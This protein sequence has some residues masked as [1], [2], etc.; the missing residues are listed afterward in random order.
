[1]QDL[2]LT[3]T[4]LTERFSSGPKAC[5]KTAIS[6]GASDHRGKLIREGRKKI[7]KTT[8]SPSPL[9]YHVFWSDA[10]LPRII[11]CPGRLAMDIKH[12]RAGEGGTD[13]VRSL[14]RVICFDKE[15]PGWSC[16]VMLKHTADTTKQMLLWCYWLSE[17]NSTRPKNSTCIRGSINKP[18][19]IEKLRYVAISP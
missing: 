11:Y 14:D 18:N 8:N 7:L 16:D 13:D 4:V 9:T 5:I 1:M 2:Q 17:S 6:S 3:S 15:A 10:Q 19:Y 12:Q